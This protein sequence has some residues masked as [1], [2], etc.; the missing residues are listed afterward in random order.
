MK[1]PITQFLVNDK[2]RICRA[3]TGSEEYVEGCVEG[4]EKEGFRK[5]SDEELDAF[6]NETQRALD[7]GWNPDRMNYLKWSAKQ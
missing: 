5:V 7:A 4:S 1:R 6:R 3:F 2:T